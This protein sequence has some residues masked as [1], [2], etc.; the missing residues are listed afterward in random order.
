MFSFTLKMWVES[1]GSRVVFLGCGTVSSGGRVA[2]HGSEYKEELQGV[3]EDDGG[4]DDIVKICHVGNGRRE[5]RK[6][7]EER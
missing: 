5:D 3:E 1:S 6:C 2:E 4:E 7:L